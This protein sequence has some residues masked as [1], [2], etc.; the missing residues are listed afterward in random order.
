MAVREFTVQRPEFLQFRFQ[1][2]GFRVVCVRLKET[3]GFAVDSR[4]WYKRHVL[5]NGRAENIGSGG[6]SAH[7]ATQAH[8]RGQAI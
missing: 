7:R 4:A 2:L 1:S 3:T 5:K 6:F 8:F